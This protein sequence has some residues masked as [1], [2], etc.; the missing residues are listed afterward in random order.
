MK[1]VVKILKTPEN[2]FLVQKRIPGVSFLFCHVSRLPVEG[3]YQLSGR[4]L[5]KQKQYYLTSIIDT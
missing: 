4:G 1:P 2:S 5:I 3:A